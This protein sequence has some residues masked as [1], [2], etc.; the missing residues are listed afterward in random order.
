MAKLETQP[1]SVS[2]ASTT[3]KKESKQ[4]SACLVRGEWASLKQEQE[5][6]SEEAACSAA[7]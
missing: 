5:I 2:V 6:E 4:K 3:K 1:W 7:E